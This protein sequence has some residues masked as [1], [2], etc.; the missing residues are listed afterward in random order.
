MQNSQNKA[1]TAL[2]EH[3]P[4]EASSTELSTTTAKLP[5]LYKKNIETKSMG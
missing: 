5:G 1:Q 2:V 4:G 3:K